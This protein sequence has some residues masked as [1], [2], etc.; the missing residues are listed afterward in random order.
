[1]APT[2]P[3]GDLP[4]ALRD[5][6]RPGLAGVVQEVIAAV[7]AEV[8]EYDQPLEG[9]FGSLIS[10]GVS[11]ALEQFVGLLGRDED[12]PDLATSA[13]L[14]RAELRAGRTLD[15]LQ[16]A[17]RVGARVAWRESA[18][19]GA[20]E[21]V[22]S[23][24][25]YRLAEAIFAYIDRLAAASVAGFTEADAIRA[26]AL[27]ARRHALLEL[28]ARATPLDR[29]E[30]DRRAQEA[31][32]SPLPRQVAALAVGVS[33]PVRI[34]RGMPSGSI[35]AALEPVGVVLVCDPDGPGRPARVR[36]AVRDRPAVLGP[37]VTWQEAQ[38]SVTRALLAWPVHA[39]GALGADSLAR[40]DDHPL[41][42][43]LAASPR[44][45]AELVARRLG[46]LAGMSDGARERAIATLQAWLDAHGDVSVAAQALHVHPQTVRY[47]LNGLREL[48]GDP[49]LDE[50]VARLELAL[51]LQAAAALVARTGRSGVGASATGASEAAAD[52][53]PPGKA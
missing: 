5:L 1:M 53:P 11:V 34:A 31:G 26:G 22:E 23:T 16:S 24:T 12:V 28:L 35:G 52:E 33:D 3:W 6:L 48:L 17:Y 7:R 30:I 49:A 25:M 19:V 4:I 45:T 50:P 38:V 9:E 39:A 8:P 42:L 41:A 21:G 27:Q 18:R 43:L 10:Q 15:A 44:L 51:A 14:G 32:L 40:T 13:R 2:Y 47:R 29:A 36:A 37:T 20:A 46:V